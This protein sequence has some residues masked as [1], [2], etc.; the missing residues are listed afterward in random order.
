MEKKYEWA[1]NISAPREYPIEVYT[2]AAGGCFFS[3]MRGFSNAGWGGGNSVDYIEAPLPERLDMTWLSYVDNKLYTGDWKLPTEKIQQ[4][5]DEGYYSR[6]GSEPEKEVYKNINIGLAPKGMVVVWVSGI[7]RQVEVAR[8]QAHETTID[9]KL[10]SESEKY[11]FREN[12]SK[13]RLANDFVI[14][15]DVREQ[16][17]QHGYPAPEVYEAYR[18]K[19]LW[20]PKVILP[21]GCRIN[22]LYIKMCNGEVE[23][24]YDRPIE[25]NHRAIPYVFEIFWYV[26][27]GKK[28]Q[29]FVS[30]IAFTKD[31]KFW[32]KYLELYGEDE[33]PVDFDKNEIRTLFKNHIDKNKAA[34]LVIKIDPTVE[35]KSQ[36]VTDLYVEQEGKRYEIKDKITRTGKYN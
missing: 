3:Q 31:E 9:P 24:P 13:D 34:E 14:S 10:I 32:A 21:E 19:Y 30:R 27:R 28:Q 29:E 11:M 2:G 7:D 4:L 5:F 20:K 33:M 22:A 25:R 12:Y 17:K 23:D 6:R 15:Q 16:L 8:F 26:G 18:E 35:L 1:A 36:R